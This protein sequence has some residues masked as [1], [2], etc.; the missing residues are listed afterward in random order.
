MH[1]TL[2]RSP[3]TNT[4][5][6]HFQNNPDIYLKADHGIRPIYPPSPLLPQYSQSQP[7]YYPP[8]PAP[9]PYTQ[10]PYTQGS[11]AY[12]T[13][14][15]A[16][17]PPLSPPFLTFPPFPNYTNW[18]YPQEQ[19][20]QHYQW[21]YGQGTYPPYAQGSWYPPHWS[22][23]PCYP[24]PPHHITEAPN[25]NT[26][27]Q[28]LHP[29]MFFPPAPWSE[30]HYAATASQ[31][32]GSQS[33]QA[34]PTVSQ[35]TQPASGNELTPPS[36]PEKEEK[37]M[38]AEQADKKTAIDEETVPEESTEEKEKEK[39]EKE[40]GNEKKDENNWPLVVGQGF[41]FIF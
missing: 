19:L 2:R 6:Q 30:E 21:S 11:G 5:L 7:S 8:A 41:P 16:Q 12:P 18:T 1:H 24:E 29:E 28:T 17:V 25:L 13:G 10:V 38:E 15:Y 32:L 35:Y 22:E 14:P 40:A 20:P 34:Q 9:P 33:A 26:H 36:S 23:P 27:T 31:D 3:N 37:K 39:K 4:F